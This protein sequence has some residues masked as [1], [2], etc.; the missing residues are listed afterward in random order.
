MEC[1]F[2]PF[3]A[4]MLKELLLGRTEGLE[5][6]LF[7]MKDAFSKACEYMAAESLIQ[8]LQ[9]YCQY[10][11][12]ELE[13]IPIQNTLGEIPKDHWDEAAETMMKS[14]QD[15]QYIEHELQTAAST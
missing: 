14:V 9:I 7:A 4:N 5:L 12:I 3:K 2:S 11:V 8:A 10:H 6:K 15:P 1:S 13:K